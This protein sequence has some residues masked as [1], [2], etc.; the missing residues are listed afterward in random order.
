MDTTTKLILLIVVI[1]LA[2]A[3]VVYI[4]INCIT[5]WRV[6]ECARLEQERLE[7]EAHE[8]EVEEGKKLLIDLLEVFHKK[9]LNEEE[10]EDE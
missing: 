5:S 3:L 2:T 9:E 6:G 8:K 1:I 10:S 4:I 7:R